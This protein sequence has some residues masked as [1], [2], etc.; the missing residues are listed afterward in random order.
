MTVLKA[1]FVEALD[2]NR[3]HYQGRE[4]HY[5]VLRVFVVLHGGA[6]KYSTPRKSLCPYINKITLE[7]T[8]ASFCLEKLFSLQFVFMEKTAFTHMHCPIVN[9][10][11]TQN[12]RQV[13]NL[14]DL[15]VLLQE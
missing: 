8:F 4:S 6:N 7:L 12:N 9:N 13:N 1:G 2:D 15:K 5:A 10:I 3:H 11:Q 14:Q